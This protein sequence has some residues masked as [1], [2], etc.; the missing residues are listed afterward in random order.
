MRKVKLAKDTLPVQDEEGLQPG[1]AVSTQR[2]WGRKADGPSNSPVRSRTGPCVGP[3]WV[4]ILLVLG[5][6]WVL[7]GRPWV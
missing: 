3:P 2:E 6:S 4:L 5:G 7:S 1:E